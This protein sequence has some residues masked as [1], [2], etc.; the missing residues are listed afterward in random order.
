MQSVQD[1]MV[2]LMDSSDEVAFHAG[3]AKTDLGKQEGRIQGG[4]T[5]AQAAK[6]EFFT[7]I[8]ET[9]A[10]LAASQNEDIDQVKKKKRK[11]KAFKEKLNLLMQMVENMDLSELA[12]EDREVI[13]EFIRNAKTISTLQRDLKFLDDKEIY[14]QGIVDKQKEGG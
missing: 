5:T 9:A 2:D 6:P 14:Y 8:D 3:S 11:E 12:P 10:A 1:L 7:H 13:E 4:K